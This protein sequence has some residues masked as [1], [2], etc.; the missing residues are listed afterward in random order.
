MCSDQVCQTLVRERQRH[1]NALLP[2]PSPTF[3]KVPERE[4]EP[5][6]HPLMM[7]DGQ[8]DGQVMCPPRSA[9]KQL[10][11]ELRLR[12]GWGTA[13]GLN[14][15]EPRLPRALPQ[16]DF[17]SAGSTG[18]ARTLRPTALKI[19]LQIAADTGGTPDSP[20]PPGGASL[21]AT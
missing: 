7:G 1:R 8:R 4:Q 12:F 11:A 9:G 20:T 10:E 6:V 19:A 14:V 3:G 17:S 2:N 18:R 16:A 5:L 13:R 15:T 21:R